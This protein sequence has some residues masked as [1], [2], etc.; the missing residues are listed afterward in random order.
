MIPVTKSTLATILGSANG[1]FA[2]NLLPPKMLGQFSVGLAKK[3]PN[4]GPKIDPMLQT[5]GIIENARGCN[6]FS[7][8]ISA[9]IV[10]MMPTVLGQSS[11]IIKTIE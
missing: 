11:P 5:N 1:Y 2:R 9:T 4:E 6:S 7:G 8:T 3:P 10:L